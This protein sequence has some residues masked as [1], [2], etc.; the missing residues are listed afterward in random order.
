M[1]ERTVP[2]G[3]SI[4]RDLGVV[5]VGPGEQQQGVTVGLG[6]LAQRRRQL[7]SEPL[8][9]EAADRFVLGAPIGEDRRATFGRSAALRGA[10][11]MAQEVAGDRV[12]P[13]PGVLVALVIAVATVERQPEG[14]GGDVLAGGTGA[15]GTDACSS[16]Q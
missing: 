9:F 14:L 16:A 2:T 15:A 4:A 3:I 6:Q 12:Q 7:R 8:P 13:R 5:Q 10:E 1:R 11:V